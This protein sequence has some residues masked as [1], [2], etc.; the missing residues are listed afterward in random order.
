VSTDN[1]V[2]GFIP[3]CHRANIPVDFGFAHLFS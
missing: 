1:L 2:E 3:P